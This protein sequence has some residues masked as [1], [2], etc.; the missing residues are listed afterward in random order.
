MKWLGVRPPVLA[1]LFAAFL[2]A[3]PLAAQ[4]MLYVLDSSDGQ[5]HRVLKVVEDRPYILAKGALVASGDRRFV[6]KKVEEFL[7]CFI[8]IDHKE[9]DFMGTNIM[10]QIPALTVNKQIRFRAEFN[11]AYALDDVFLV[12]EVEFAD[13]INMLIVREVGKLE[14]HKPLPFF[15]NAD[16]E[17][18]S[19]V[20]QCRVHLFAKGSEVFT[21]E[22]PPAF[23]EEM[24]ARMIRTRTDS[25]RQAGPMFLLCPAPA[26][27]ESL[28]KLGARGRAVVAVRITE[29][30]GVLEPAVA[31]AS[32]P[33]FGEAA[34]A[35]VREWR[36]VPRVKEGKPVEA[37]V[38]IPFTF[39]PPMA[40]GH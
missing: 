21:S 31:S 19:A 22:Q 16:V 14:P 27:P 29:Q 7:P 10:G 3:A 15:A 8:A 40:G 1:T 6:I 35:A 12:L 37:Q 34:L 9:V 11:S 36:F 26:Y 25:V 2:M 4:S 32:D 30:G 5:Y 20:R 24:I 18:D 17:R 28:K 13:G 23:R 33:A 39:D 38:N